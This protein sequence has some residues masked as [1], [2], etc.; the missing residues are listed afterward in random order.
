MGVGAAAG[1]VASAET[2]PVAGDGEAVAVAGAAP[3]IERYGD[4]DV[5]VGASTAEGPVTTME[6]GIPAPKAAAAAA[7]GR[8]FLSRT[9]LPRGPARGG[10]PIF[11]GLFPFWSFLFRDL[12]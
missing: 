1:A 7:A 12:F 8:L 3:F 5:T 10:L 4:D 2:T 9:P 6:E 11:F